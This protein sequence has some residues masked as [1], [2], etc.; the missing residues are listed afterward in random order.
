MLAAQTGAQARAD[1]RARLA[2]SVDCCFCRACRCCCTMPR[3][4]DSATS[5]GRPGLLSCGSCRIWWWSS[6]SASGRSDS[7]VPARVAPPC[8]RRPSCFPALWLFGAIKGW[9]RHRFAGRRPLRGQPPAARFVSRLRPANGGR[10]VL[11]AV[12]RGLDRAASATDC[13]RS[14]GGGAPVRWRRRSGDGLRRAALALLHGVHVELRSP[15]VSRRRWR[16]GHSRATSCCSCIHM[17]RSSIA[18]ILDAACRCE[19]SSSRPSRT[20]PGYVIKPRPLDFEPARRGWSEAPP[21]SRAL[22]R[23][24]VAPV[25]RLGS[26]ANRRGCSRGWTPGSGALGDLGR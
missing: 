1:V 2:H 10:A 21:S 18:G 16:T 6:S 17:K 3:S 24:P 23:R 12:R 7:A 25:L 22:G 4:I 14:T 19:G 8:R 13:R 15:A 11:C 5:S 26:R 9:Q 20:R